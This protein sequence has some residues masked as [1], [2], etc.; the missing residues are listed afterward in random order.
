VAQEDDVNG[1]S[2]YDEGDSQRCLKKSGDCFAWDTAIGDGTFYWSWSSCCTD[3][4][5][6]GEMQDSEWEMF[7]DYTDIKNLETFRIGSYG[8]DPAKP[9]E[10]SFHE[11]PVTD[12]YF[13]VEA[14]TCDNLCFREFEKTFGA[15]AFENEAAINP[16]CGTKAPDIGEA[17]HDGESF[18]KKQDFVNKL[19]A[20]VIDEL[21]DFKRDEYCTDTC[22]KAVT[23]LQE[24]CMEVNGDWAATLVR[25]MTELITEAATQCIAT[26][27]PTAKPTTHAPTH[28]GDTDSPSMPPT[29]DD[30]EVNGVTAPAPKLA[31]L[32]AGA[33]AGATLASVAF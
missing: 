29:E 2:Y 12:H 8:D 6:M 18:T 28:L 9:S 15:P 25:D 17:P 30:S 3:G 31:L 24:V 10:M 13:K 19:R 14:F 16:M 26:E 11:L 22:L 20:A 7:L 1:A 23:H 5:V 33:A 32:A 4:M 27:A 21:Q